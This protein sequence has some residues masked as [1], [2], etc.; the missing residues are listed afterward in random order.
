M[1]ILV[2]SK[3]RVVVQGITGREG[4]FHTE[5]MQEFGTQVV[6]GVAP[7]KGGTMVLNL[8]VFNTVWDA[9][10]STAATASVIFVPAPSAADAVLEAVDAG[11]KVIATITEGVPIQDAIRMA[12]AARKADAHLI[13]P[14]TPGIGTA[15][16]CKLGIMPNDILQKKG[17]V[18]LISRSGTLTYEIVHRIKESGLGIST[19]VGVGGDPIPG[20]TISDLLQLFE[21]DPETEAVVIIGEIGGS[22]EERSAELIPTLPKL[23]NRVVAFISGRTAPPGKRMGHAGAIISGGRGTAQGKVEAYQKAGIP[24]ADSI[25]DILSI[26][27]SFF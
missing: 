21:K 27:K 3:T 8:P 18:G 6:S 23:K 9:I 7:G 22:D 16:E 10:A 13:G 20:S 5:R 2:N 15:T 24:V 11:L 25:P 12:Q 14:N 4:M 26:L 1:G 17:P 19:A